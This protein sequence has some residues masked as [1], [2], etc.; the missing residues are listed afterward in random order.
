MNLPAD[1]VAELLAIAQSLDSHQPSSAKL[2][3]RHVRLSDPTINVRAKVPGGIGGNDLER[4]VA[5]ID[6]SSGGLQIIWLAFVHTGTEFSLQLQRPGG[7]MIEVEATSVWCKHLRNRFHAV[8]LQTKSTLQLHEIVSQQVWL[9]ACAK[10]PELQHPVSGRLAIYGENELMVQ[11]AVFQTQDSGLT[12]QVVDSRGVLM[13]LIERGEI[14]MLVFDADPESLDATEFISACRNRA[15]SGPLILMSL[16]TEAEYLAKMDPLHRSRFVQLPM[17]TNAI[18]AAIRDVIRTHPDCLLNS[19]EIYSHSPMTLHRDASLKRFISLA[20]SMCVEANTAM[21]VDRPDAVLK[22]VQSLAAS[23]GSHGYPDLS[24]AA[25]K[26]IAA[27][28][29]PKQVK[30]LPSLLQ[31]IESIVDRLR[32]GQPGKAAA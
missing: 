4:N 31:N 27:A 21:D 32:P 12:T 5:L 2:R 25:M 14:D 24:V 17:G 18:V 30:R 9:E 8:G 11:S 15:F 26:Y 16:D 7:P 13:D 10:N 22:V 6:I 23:G 19:G 20:K 1:T 3:R 28:N 29:D